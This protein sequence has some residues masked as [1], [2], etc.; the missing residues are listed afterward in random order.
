M[1]GQARHLPIAGP[2]H[3][4]K[5]KTPPGSADGVRESERW[6]GEPLAS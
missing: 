3:T 5:K 2:H 6:I 1:T 4:P